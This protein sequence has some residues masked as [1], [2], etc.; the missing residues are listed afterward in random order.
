MDN[1]DDQG[2]H[3]DTGNYVEESRD[4]NPDE[5]DT[6]EDSDES[7]IEKVKDALGV[8]GDETYEDDDNDE[9]EVIVTKEEDEEIQ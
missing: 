6:N 8:T 9:D 5:P 4:Y 1:N 2:L 3:L 7:L